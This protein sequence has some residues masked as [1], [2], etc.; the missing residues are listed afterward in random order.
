MNSV[1]NLALLPLLQFPTKIVVVDDNVTYTDSLKS[2]A[3]SKG[4]DV[5]TFN[6][7]KE[8]LAYLKDRS[9]GKFLDNILQINTETLE[10][11]N[12]VINVDLSHVY[13]LM[14]N[15]N[16][17]GEASVVLLD[18]AMPGLNGREFCEAIASLPVQK[19]LLTGEAT[20]EDAVKM[21]NNGSIDRF[22]KKDEDLDFLFASIA[23]HQRRY[24]VDLTKEIMYSLQSTGSLTF[25]DQKFIEFFSSLCQQHRFIEYYAVDDSGSYLLADRFGKLKLLI[26]K[27]EEDM[28]FLYEFAEGDDTASP[29]LL[30]ALRNGQKLAFF[31]S[32]K[33]LTL[34]T[35]DWVI[36]DAQQLEGNKQLYT[37]ALVDVGK[38]FSIDREKI[39]P[40]DSYVRS[41]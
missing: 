30:T 29:E 3:L 10:V 27:S 25:S 31:Q 4:F 17:F 41:K 5:I 15:Q 36:H 8:A 11:L 9:Y 13:K 14:F 12:K 7:P 35:K 18:Y 20:Y 34:A 24:F 33:E 32:D 38:D 28:R 21:F 22:F 23:E 39:V 40:F 16:R 6:D 1:K 26:V 2:V 19:L 37:Y